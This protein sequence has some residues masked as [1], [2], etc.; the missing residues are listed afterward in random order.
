MTLS[1]LAYYKIKDFFQ[2]QKDEKKRI[3]FEKITVAQ[4]FIQKKEWESISEVDRVC[5]YSS[6]DA[7]SKIPLYVAAQ[8]KYYRDHGFKIVFV[9]TSQEL[10][11]DQME[12]LKET[13]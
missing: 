10:P 7:H 2:K 8:L 3:R 9:T 5:L 11:D 1:L 6:Y 4:T 12:L 13:C